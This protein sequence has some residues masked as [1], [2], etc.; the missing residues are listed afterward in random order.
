MNTHKMPL[1]YQLNVQM[2]R[3]FRLPDLP[4]KPS[5]LMKVDCAHAPRFVPIVL[6]ANVIIMCCISLLCQILSLTLT[7]QYTS[8]L[9]KEGKVV[10]RCFG[11]SRFHTS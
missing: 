2:D 3:N 7:I 4:E 11:V 9:R 6:C 1:G 10:C 8:C 5:H